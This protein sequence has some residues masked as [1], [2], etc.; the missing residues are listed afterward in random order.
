MVKQEGRT[1]LVQYGCGHHAPAGWRNFD[2]SPTLRLERL[3]IVGKLNPRNADRFP[4]NVEYGDI[5][6]GLPLSNES[7]SAIYASHVL[8]HLS[9]EDFQKA[10]VNTFNLLRPGGL[11]RLVVPDL[12]VLAKRYLD[13]TES[14]AA[15]KFMKE[16]SLGV[17]TRNRSVPG[18]MR[19]WLG[20][21]KHLWMWD[22]KSLRDELERA[23]FAD[24]HRCSYGDELVFEAVE[25]RARFIDCL[26]IQCRKP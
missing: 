16:T 4:A 2:C 6:R 5:V 18:L 9:L 26:A 14:L 1:I 22:F 19:S 11:F 23:G 12:E 25:E 10:V 21:S 24:I 7:C 8:E 3:P 17:E 13:S 20:N 15:V